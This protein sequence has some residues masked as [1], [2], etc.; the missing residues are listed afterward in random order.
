MA[1]VVAVVIVVVIVVVINVLGFF[2]AGMSMGAGGQTCASQI[3]TTLGQDLVLDTIVTYHSTRF[4]TFS[5][6][7][8]C[9]C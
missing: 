2:G 7:C 4:E 9:C 5:F 6:C 1:V 3:L 8:C